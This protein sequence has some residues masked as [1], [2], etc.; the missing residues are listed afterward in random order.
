MLPGLAQNSG[1]DPERR[2]DARARC[3]VGVSAEADGLRRQSG[4]PIGKTHSSYL[5]E[6]GYS[7]SDSPPWLW[8]RTPPQPTNNLVKYA[9]EYEL[10]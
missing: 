9:P 3:R 6:G 10:V 7:L 8:T 2:R 4:H 1:V 5:R